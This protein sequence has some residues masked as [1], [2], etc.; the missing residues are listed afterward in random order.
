M[1]SPLN[2][3]L[4]TLNT[5]DASA[6]VGPLRLVVPAPATRFVPLG[7]HGSRLLSDYLA[8]RHLSRIDRLRTLVVEDD[9]GIVAVVGHT[10]GQ[11]VAISPTT[12]RV[13]HLEIATK[14]AP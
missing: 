1:E 14:K 2:S 11:R 12:Q 3:Q 4:S 13:V 5:L 10:V 7:M 8:D 9:L 6:V